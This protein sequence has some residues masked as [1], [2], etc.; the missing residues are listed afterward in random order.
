MLFEA[1]YAENYAS[2]LYQCLPWI[3]KEDH[4][5]L[6]YIGELIQSE[7]VFS[8]GPAANSSPH[9]KLSRKLA[10]VGII[11]SQVLSLF[12]DKGRRIASWITPEYKSEGPWFESWRC[13]ALPFFV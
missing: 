13:C 4:A 6:V 9:G 2:I 8:C 1:D 7:T 3:A 12:S 5:K 10:L 11:R